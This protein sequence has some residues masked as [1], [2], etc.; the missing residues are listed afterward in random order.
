MSTEKK[1][2][3]K[4]TGR[5]SLATI[6]SRIL[7]LLREVSFAA[8]FG[9]AG[10]MDAFVAA[11]RIPNL[12]RDL[13]AEGA[14]SAAYVPVFTEKLKKEGVQKA[15]LVTSSVFSII[16]VVLGLLVVLAILLAP[17]YVKYY[18]S[19]FG[20]DAAQMALTVRLTQ[21]MFPFIL[22]IAFAAVSMGTLNSIGRFGIPALAPAL[23]NVVMI[24]SALYLTRYFNPPILGL[25]FG[26]VIGGGGQFIIQIPQLLRNGYRYEFR[27]D[28][29]N[30]AV[31][32]IF[33]LMLPAALGVAAWQINV[34]VATI[35]ASYLD[36]GS[37]S[38]LYYALRLMHL[39]LG[40]FG[41]ALAAVSLPEISGLVA[42][43]DIKGAASAQRFSS[44][45]V[46]FLL[47]PSA[48]FLIGAAEAIVSTVYQR[49]NFTW[50]DTV[51]VALAL[52][53]YAIGLVFF[54]LVRVTA[55]VFYAFK[56]TRTPV[57]ISILAVAVN[58]V[59]SLIFI[60]P[61]GF[62]GLALATS[63]SAIVNFSF[64]SFHSHRKAPPPDSFGLLRYFLKILMVSF[65][66]GLIALM[67]SRFILGEGTEIA[68]SQAVL[69][70]VIAG[71]IAG[72]IYLII[73]ALLKIDELEQLKN[74]FK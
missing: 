21:I 15:F 53:A 14:L 48:A 74:L 59:L 3:L 47:L 66:A 5:F 23:F 54:G 68:F 35:I 44:R 71:L 50:D 62:A 13:F 31:R 56:D 32:K 51:N 17:Y 55:Q 41:V 29:R 67:V 11:F 30:E 28:F 52:R 10:N 18:V 64:L 38:S 60:R 22:L 57:K 40:I 72:S 4:S 37:I 63:I 69:A 42:S 73:C 61:F 45:M 25:G 1:T 12:L 7:G 27:L 36:V 33:K 39:P 43:G 9:A 26:A 65:I 8:V 70:T 49:G 24:L 2:F 46:I 16:L 20:D 34:V 6:V 19:G 58:I